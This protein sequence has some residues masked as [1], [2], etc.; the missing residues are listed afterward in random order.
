MEAA[1][2][3]A[4]GRGEGTRRQA[5]SAQAS[6]EEGEGSASTSAACSRRRSRNAAGLKSCWALA[7][8]PAARAGVAA[9]GCVSWPHAGRGAG[10][11]ERVCVPGVGRVRVSPRR[12]GGAAVAAL[13]AAASGGGDRVDVYPHAEH[14]AARF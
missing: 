1:D 2:E 12:D 8:P 14:E 10:G 7:R 5:A 6:A 11:D 3:A 13:R 9:Q 4:Q